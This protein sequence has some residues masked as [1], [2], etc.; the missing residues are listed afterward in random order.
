MK[1][2]RHGKCHTK[3]CQVYYSIR[4]RCYNK[5]CK[6]Y[7]YY[8]ARGIVICTEWLNCFQAFYSWAMDNGYKE[9]LTI[10]RIN[11]DG[12]YEPGNCRWVGRT[13]QNRNM[14][15]NIYLT[16]N[17]RSQIMKDWARELNINYSTIKARHLKG[18][19]DEECLFGKGAKREKYKI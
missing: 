7:K 15:K 2:E 5:K 16:Y 13:T 14:R 1:Y 10:D 8:G 18:W 17:N 6:E 3:L 11:V 19:S 12:N 4:K 9:G